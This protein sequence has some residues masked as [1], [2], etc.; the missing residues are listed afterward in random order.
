MQLEAKQL[1]D[2]AVAL[3]TSGHVCSLKEAME[4]V[5][6]SNR[7]L[8]AEITASLDPGWPHISS[9]TPLQS[10]PKQMKG[11]PSTSRGASA[12]SGQS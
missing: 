10:A 6:E 4:D 7:V 11:A 5:L 1:W 12:R 2:A 8:Q 3:A 9:C